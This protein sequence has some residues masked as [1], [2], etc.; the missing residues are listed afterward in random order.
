MNFDKEITRS[1]VLRHVEDTTQ[2]SWYME[3][4]LGYQFAEYRFRLWASPRRGWKI[5]ATIGA[6]GGVVLTYWMFRRYNAH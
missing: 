2:D 3:R 1:I 6:A 5:I 4:R